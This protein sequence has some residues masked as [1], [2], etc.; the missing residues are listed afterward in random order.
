MVLYF[1]VRL[2]VVDGDG[3]QRVF[4]AF[5]RESDAESEM[6]RLAALLHGAFAVYQGAPVASS[7]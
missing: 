1:V 4:G 5:A 3:Q 2:D 6:T 7:Q